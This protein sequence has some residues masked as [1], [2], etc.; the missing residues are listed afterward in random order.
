M[1]AFIRRAGVYVWHTMVC[2]AAL[3]LVLGVFWAFSYVLSVHHRRQAE[4]MLQQLAVLQPGATDFYTVQRIARDSGGTEHCTEELCRYDFDDRFMFA[5]SRL[6]RLLRRTEWDSLGLRPWLV[7]VVIRKRSSGLTDVEVDAGVGRGRGWLVNEGLFSGNIWASWTVV[8]E[9]SAGEF[10][11][12]LGRE[13]EEILSYGRRTTDQI[14]ASSDGIAVST[15]NFTTPGGGELLKV[16][17]S[18]KA[19]SDIRRAAFD[20]NLRCATDITP[21]TQL[22]Q[23]AP[24]AWHSHIQ[25]MKSNGLP[26]GQSAE[27]AVANRR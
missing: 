7:S 23:L 6:P 19:S 10:D 16:R 15:P 12:A 4:D 14:E 24:S 20:L 22:C 8:V 11:N 27:C 9:T 13:K 25:F 3:A 1:R 17:L 26:V 18:P 5:D 2:M 21:C